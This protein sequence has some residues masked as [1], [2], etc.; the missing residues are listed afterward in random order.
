[1]HVFYR[2][3]ARYVYCCQYTHI[4]CKWTV[5]PVWVWLNWNGYKEEQKNRWGFFNFSVPYLIFSPSK[6]VFQINFIQKLLL[7]AKTRW[8]S[9]PVALIVSYLLEA[10]FVNFSSSHSQLKHLETQW[11]MCPVGLQ[12]RRI[13]HIAHCVSRCFKLVNNA[14]RVKEKFWESGESPQGHQ[15]AWGFLPKGLQNHLGDGQLV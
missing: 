14:Y 15:S 13:G 3:Y 2:L 4:Y 8:A 6:A 10:F 5:G 9:S 11:A 7:L 1:M 12:W